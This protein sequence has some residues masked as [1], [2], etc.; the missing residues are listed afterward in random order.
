MRVL[1]ASG[2][3]GGH[4]FPAL[5]V[6][7][8]IRHRRPDARFE[9]LGARKLAIEESCF[10]D[11][12]RVIRLP[13]VGMPR[14]FSVD[15]ASFAM[16]MLASL[17]VSLRAVTAFRPHVAIGFGNFSSVAPLAAARLRGVPVVLHEANAIPG[18]ANRLLSRLSSAVLVNFPAAAAHFP[19]GNVEA[20]GM[21]L[22]REFMQPRDR[23][24]ALATIPNFCSTILTLMVV[25]GS[26]GARALNREICNAL[27][28]L[29]KRS[30]NLQVIHLT[31][32][33]DYP[34][35][36][37]RYDALPFPAYVAAFESRMKPLYDAADLVVARSGA[38]TLAEII[39]TAKPAILVPFPHAVSGHQEAN[40]RHLEAK[41]GAIVLRQQISSCG[42]ETV[43][44]LSETL[45]ELISDRDRRT[46]MEAVNRQL[47]DGNAA[48]SIANILVD[49]ASC[50]TSAGG[51]A[52]SFLW[53]ARVS[54]ANLKLSAV[55][56]TRLPMRD[57]VSIGNG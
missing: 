18:K 50:S 47:A 57:P 26:Q 43:P 41:G 46:R 42:Q 3:T 40:A 52:R 51:E 32:A 55:Q 8:E 11:N 45:G 24:G 44:G 30:L 33:A 5:A 14:T 25:G 35:V 13:A 34:W 15:C 23:L 7:E 6:A 20:V 56:R 27:V 22:R 38:S 28:I 17:D 21:P 10:G 53:R 31:G 4:V 39:H 9:F 1:I 36:R 2:G 12:A 16:R 19:N 49:F 54:R 48:R 37:R 29:Q